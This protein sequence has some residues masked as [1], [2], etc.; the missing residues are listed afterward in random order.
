M[1]GI[2]IR[3][4]RPDDAEALAATYRDAYQQSRELGFPM[5]AGSATAQQVA[6]WIRDDH[7]LVAV[8]DEELVG[9]ARLSH[10]EPSVTKVSRVGVRESRKG[11]GIGSRLLAA[12]EEAARERGDER[13]RLT[14]PEEHPFLVEFYESRG[15]EIVGDYPLDFREYDEVILEKALA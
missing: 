2:R 7:V 8:D 9:G 5:K 12:A 14:T 1:P 11:E 15:Y 10:P 13:A 3:P 6:E 4:A